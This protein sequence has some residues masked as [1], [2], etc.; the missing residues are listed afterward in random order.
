M[1]ETKIYTKEEIMLIAKNLV[2][3]TFGEINNYKTVSDSY[4]KGSY[5]HIL[6]EDA[7]H[8]SIN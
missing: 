7:Y 4:N 6:E 2:G 1:A 8:Y 5:G 3:K